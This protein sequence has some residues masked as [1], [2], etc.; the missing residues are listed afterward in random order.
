M[1]ATVIPMRIINNS[2]RTGIKL[3]A[4]ASGVY[5]KM[6]VNISTVNDVYNKIGATYFDKKIY[7]F[8]LPTIPSVW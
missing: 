2:K 5:G 7:E 6:I 3:K 4:F 8:A 1:S